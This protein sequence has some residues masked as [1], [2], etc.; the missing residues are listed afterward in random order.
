MATQTGSRKISVKKQEETLIDIKQVGNR[1]EQFFERYQKPLLYGIMAILA[2]AATYFAYNNL[3][4]EPKQKEAIQAMYKA[5]QMMERDS[6]AQALNGG[7]YNGFLDIIKKYGGVP[8]GNLSKYYAGV[9]YINLGKFDDAVSQLESFSPAGSI[10]PTMKN[11]LLGDAYSEKKDYAKALQS[12]KKAA[13]EGDVDN[14]KAVYLK[15]YAM[16]SEIQHDVPSALEAYKTIKEKY[17]ATDAA[18]DIEKYIARAEGAK[19]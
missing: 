6:F 8:A 12:Y 16:L 14:L 5:E 17:S 18:R 13:T 1:T 9:C 3:Y 19:K 4:K 2:I 7:G 10:T 15:R 11:G